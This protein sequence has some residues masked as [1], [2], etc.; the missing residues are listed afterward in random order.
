V[1]AWLIAIASRD[2][3][4][5]AAGAAALERDGTRALAVPVD[6]RDPA[7][8]K[9]AFAV[10]QPEIVVHMAAQSLVRASYHDP[11]ATYATNVL[12]TVNVLEAARHAPGI[13]AVL[14]V[15]SDKCYEN[16][17]QSRARVESDAL[18]G[19]DPY[20]SSKACA[21]IVTSAYR[22][23]F[24]PA[25]RA[26]GIAVAS[27]RAG[28]VI[29]GGDWAADRLIPDMVR[30]YTA[31]R[32]VKLRNPSATRPW[33]HVLDPLNGYLTLIE[34]LCVA[35]AQFAEAW[36]FGPDTVGER[37]VDA[38]ADAMTGLWGD[39]AGWEIDN[40][41]H[42]HE[43]RRLALDSGKAR[44]RLGWMPRLDLAQSL[45]WT[46]NWYKRHHGGEDARELSRAQISSYLEL[47]A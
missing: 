32:R 19:H 14:I 15:T 16:A 33:Q 9:A 45:Q 44:A 37:R 25:A 12:G 17:D 30:A 23:S 36:N 42:Q 47:A 27:A 29:G 3:A 10:H 6:V 43:A 11:V 40:D 46:V 35:G 7:A 13:N 31:G 21:E 1:P 18:G 5:R 8:L 28:N 41:N 2:E 26:G 34:K 22:R 4:H 39:G 20:S 38:L 24:F